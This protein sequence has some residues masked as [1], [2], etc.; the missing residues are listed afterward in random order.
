MEPARILRYCLAIAALVICSGLSGMVSAGNNVPGGAV[1]APVD[2][3]WVDSFINPTLIERYYT[4]GL[5]QGRSYCVEVQPNQN[6]I[7]TFVDAQTHIFT[8]ATAATV[9]ATGDDW[10]REPYAG[11]YPKMCFIWTSPTDPA[12]LINIQECCGRGAP[13]PGDTFNFR[14]RI[15]DTTLNG[16]WFF[17]NTPSSY[18]AFIE[19]TNT[20]SSPTNISVTI[21][22]GGGAQIGTPFTLL[23]PGY[24]NIALN[25]RT[26][27]GAVIAD[28]SGSV[29]IAH[30]GP[31][32]GIY[33][34]VTSLSA[35]TGLSFDSPLSRRQN[36]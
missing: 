15:V 19:I 14:F 2:N 3:A 20:T 16:P 8:D 7:D 25:A 5:F 26:D 30:D 22:N 9:F 31:P 10:A 4:V 24:S 35:L 6:Q 17:V 13:V 12:R 18:N 11:L 34:N 29:Q 21:R 33:A 28:G 1:V 27:F 32:G 23:M 36:W